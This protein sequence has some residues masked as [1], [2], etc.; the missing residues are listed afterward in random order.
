MKEE[1]TRKI[2]K[3]LNGIILKQLQDLWTHTEGN[4]Y[5]EYNINNIMLIINQL[6]SKK[7]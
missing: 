7:L 2:R 1:I 3:Y 6:A 4:L 5:F